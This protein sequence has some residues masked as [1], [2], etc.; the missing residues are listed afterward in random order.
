MPPPD[1]PLSL[2]DEPLAV[3][4]PWTVTVP[5]AAM[6]TAPPPWPPHRLGSPAPP[7]PGASGAVSEP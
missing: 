6:R 4:T 1:P 5:E 2:V 3:I 7:L